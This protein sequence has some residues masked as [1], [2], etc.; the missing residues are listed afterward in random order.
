[1]ASVSKR[2]IRSRKDCPS[3]VFGPSEDAV[4]GLHSVWAR[5]LYVEEVAVVK[6]C[7]V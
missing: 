7:A 6:Y 1:M 2:D 3:E 4:V 5:V